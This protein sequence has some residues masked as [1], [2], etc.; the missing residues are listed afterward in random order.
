MITI[1]PIYSTLEKAWHCIYS[2]DCI[3]YSLQKMVLQIYNLN[4]RLFLGVLKKDCFLFLKIIFLKFLFSLTF[5]IVI[6]I[7]CCWFKDCSINI[8]IGYGQKPLKMT[9][10]TSVWVRSTHT[11]V[12]INNNYRFVF[13]CS[14][15]QS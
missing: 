5:W 3:D 2:T 7:A 12:K 1:R 10:S 4:E 13:F 6:V 15:C 8:Q 14:F 11:L 9:I